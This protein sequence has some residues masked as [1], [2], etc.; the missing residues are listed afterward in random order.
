ML[1]AKD[2]IKVGDLGGA[3]ELKS[4]NNCKT[5]FRKKSPYDYSASYDS[6]EISN[7]CEFD[8]VGTPLYMS[9]EL[10]TQKEYTYNTD[11]WSAGCVLF[12][13]VSF[14]KFELISG[15]V[16]LDECGYLVRDTELQLN[17]IDLQKNID[18][19]IE[20]LSSQ[21]LIKQLLK[22]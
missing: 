12:E 11:C 4:S 19:L 7:T 2:N 15:L 6:S 20:N 18:I 17:E 22:K 3:I 21:G 9:P 1:T 16:T 14:E 10:M 5:S 8:A 13:M